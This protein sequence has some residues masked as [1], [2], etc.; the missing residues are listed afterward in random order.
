VADE[1]RAQ[2]QVGVHAGRHGLKPRPWHDRA[3]RF[4]PLV[5]AAAGERVLA[6]VDRPL[7]GGDGRAAQVAH[8]HWD[9]N[10]LIT[11]MRSKLE[12]VVWRAKH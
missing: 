5:H 1:V 10:E 3:G 2:R 8:D 11:V 6:A 7:P 12:G 9:T 4:K